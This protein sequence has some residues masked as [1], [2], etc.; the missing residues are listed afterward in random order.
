MRR[1]AG[2]AVEMDVVGDFETGGE[3]IF[4]GFDEVRL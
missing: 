2:L 4:E 1:D 3:V